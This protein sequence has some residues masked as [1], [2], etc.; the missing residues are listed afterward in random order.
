MPPTVKPS[1]ETAA[2]FGPESVVRIAVAAASPPAAESA[3]A[4]GPT[5]A[6]IWSIGSVAPMTPVDSTTTSVA[7]R[8]IASAGLWVEEV[9]GR[10]RPSRGG[11]GPP[12]A[13]GPAP[14][15]GPPRGPRPPDPRRVARE[16]PGRPRGRLA[17]GRGRRRGGPPRQR[18]RAR[19]GG[20]Q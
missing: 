13:G 10:G 8:P 9:G 1:R 7:S 20:G 2:V 15:H 3:A 12:G 5:P 14:P 19:R 4:S 6:S 16:Q 18:A 17:G 11:G